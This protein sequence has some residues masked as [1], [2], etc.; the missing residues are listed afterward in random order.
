MDYRM[1]GFPG[2]TCR[3]DYIRNTLEHGVIVSTP[4]E[5]FNVAA[6]HSHWGAID[7]KISDVVDEA[8]MSYDYQ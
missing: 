3:M 4:G 8:L 7:S 2:N 5:E 6:V 1:P